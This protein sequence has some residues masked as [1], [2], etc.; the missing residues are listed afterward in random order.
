MNKFL[1][2]C[3]LIA[4]VLTGVWLW[5][6]GNSQSAVNNKNTPIYTDIDSIRLK[7]MLSNKDFY[8]INVH[9]P[10]QGEI[11]KT[12]AFIPYDQIDKNLN[13]LPKDKNAKIVLYCQSGRMSAIA[14]KR[15]TEL[16]YTDVYNH[17]LGMHDWQSKGYPLKTTNYL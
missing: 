17:I 5:L 12:D 6:K 9:T 13:K 4:L 11:E 14:A 16:G 10:Y 8:F 3:L 1:Y 7:A 2:F 15:L